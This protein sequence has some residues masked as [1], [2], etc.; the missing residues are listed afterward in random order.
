MA[1]TVLEIAEFCRIVKLPDNVS[2]ED[3]VVKFLSEPTER[4]WQEYVDLMRKNDR[5]AAKKKIKQ[6]LEK[7]PNKV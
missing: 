5:K 7:M 3:V 4:T 6:Q 2:K 1:K